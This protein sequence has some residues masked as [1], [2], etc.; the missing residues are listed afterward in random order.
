[1]AR[2]IEFCTELRVESHSKYHSEFWWIFTMFI[3]LFSQVVAGNVFT[4]RFSCL[5]T[6][7]HLGWRAKWGEANFLIQPAASSYLFFCEFSHT[8]A[9]FLETQL[10][11]SISKCKCLALSLMLCNSVI[12]P[13]VI[14]RCSGLWL[15]LETTTGLNVWLSVCR[16][17]D[18]QWMCT[19]M[20][21][22]VLSCT[23]SLN[24]ASIKPC[25]C[26]LW[27]LIHWTGLRSAAAWVLC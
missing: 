11:F 22:T 9:F 26:C 16:L 20:L 14:Y 13:G 4:G 23:V 2:P 10:V 12:V 5:F 17:K 6:F 1:M 24:F 7:C 25:T 8:V 3:H 18:R 27:H 15:F 19:L 21:L